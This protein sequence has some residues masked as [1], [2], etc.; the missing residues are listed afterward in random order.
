MGEHEPIVSHGRGGQGN[1]G[2][3]STEYV[4]GGIVREGVYGDQGDGAYSAGRGGAG[5]IGSPHV[6]PTSKI[7]HDA[8]IVP[9]LAI[10]QSVDGDYHT[11]RGGQGNVHLDEEH[12]KEKEEKKH[13]GP[14]HEGLA[15]KLKHKL[16]GRK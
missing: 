1:I 14:A 11:G 16:F 2:A 12:R 9:E 5:N 3:D 7:P 13:K 6:R 4:D 8:E 15:D 10:R